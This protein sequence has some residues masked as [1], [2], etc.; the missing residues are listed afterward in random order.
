MDNLPD[1]PIG[2]ATHPV[3]D[4]TLFNIVYLLYIQFDS[5]VTTGYQGIMTSIS[6]LI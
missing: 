1:A 3:L 6:E 4:P 2:I 5:I